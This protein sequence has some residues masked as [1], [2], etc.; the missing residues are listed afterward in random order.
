V[1][2][3]MGREM[4]AVMSEPRE[5]IL[6]LVASGKVSVSDGELL[7]ASLRPAR[8]RLW[9]WLFSPF[10]LA[11][12]VWL[13]TL[14]A[15]VS[16]GSF[17]LAPLN[18][19]FDGALDLHR[20]D[21]AASW[22]VALLEQAVVWPLT[23]LVLWLVALLTRQRA[24]LLELLGFVG[25]ARLPHLLAALMVMAI[26]ASI[27]LKEDQRAAPLIL[28]TVLP[29]VA[30]TCALLVSAFRTATGSRGVKLG[31]SCFAAI[32][33]AEVVSQACLGVLS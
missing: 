2:E 7:L 24:R 16:A 5:K 28:L 11:K 10:E 21:S 33:L 26:T 30:W 25:A 27:D 9:Q 18:I 31:I 32:V 19:H 13:W 14:A 1:I 8:S 15:L 23:A 4:S 17:A 22:R 12:P 20:L 29:L 6:G 3:A